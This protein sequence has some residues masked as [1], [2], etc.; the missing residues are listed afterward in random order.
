MRKHALLSASGSKRWLACTPSARLEGQFDEVRSGYAE[1]GTMAHSLAELK[2]RHHV[3]RCVPEKE[4]KLE[5]ERILSKADEAWD[6]KQMDEATDLY[7]E[8]IA[9]RFADAQSRSEDAVLMLETR[10]DYSEYVPEGFG[11]ADAIIISDGL[12]EVID[13][14]YGKG[15]AVSAEENSQGRLYAIGALIKFGYLYNIDMANVVIAQPRLDSLSVEAISADAL[16]EWAENF[17]KPRALLAYEGAGEFVVG[18]HCRFC[19][20][21]AVCRARAEEALS[22]TAHDFE[23]PP[24]LSDDEIPGIL[25]ILDKAEAWIKDI[26]AYAYEKAL[27]GHTWEGFKLVEGRSNRTYVDEEVVAGVLLKNGWSENDI[28]TTKLKGLTAMEALV[29]KRRLNDLIGHLIIKPPG[30]LTLVPDSDR[31][32]SVISNEIKELLEG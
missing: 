12:M 23:Q 2:V 17:V 11:T 15:V 28:Y 3:L 5:K 14:K 26:R 19:R 4:Y 21:K 8:I 29:G 32:E 31:R 7:V 20:A 6:L 16:L 22:I 13:L 30:K 27:A 1:E 9:E 18:D 25:A 10:L 24:V